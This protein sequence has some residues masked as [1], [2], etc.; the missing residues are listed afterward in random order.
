M[1]WSQQKRLGLISLHFKQSSMY[2][3][4]LGKG[5]LID[6]RSPTEL[7]EGNVFSRVCL[8]VNRGSPRDHY[9]WCIARHYKAT[10]TPTSTRHGTL[11]PHLLLLTSAGHHCRPIQTC[12][13]HPVL[14]SGNWN[15]YGW[16]AAGTYPTG[17]PCCWILVLAVYL[18]FMLLFPVLTRS[19]VSRQAPVTLTNYFYM[20]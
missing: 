3:W 5:Q 10:V 7:R 20:N 1:W 15:T 11:R 14:R 13:T 2:Y 16:Q 17:I 4:W 6:F 18:L 8:S 19:K 9:P 12:S